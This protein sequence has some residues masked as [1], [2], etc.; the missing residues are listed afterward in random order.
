[1]ARGKGQKGEKNRNSGANLSC[2]AQL[3]QAAR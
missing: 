2:E 1:M 3:W